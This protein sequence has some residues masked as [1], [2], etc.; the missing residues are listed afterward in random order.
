MGWVRRVNGFQNETQNRDLLGERIREMERERESQNESDNP[1]S[2]QN[3]DENSMP[4]NV[5]NFQVQN[6]SQN[7]VS[8]RHSLCPRLDLEK[9]KCRN[10]AVRRLS[11]A[12]NHWYCTE[13]AKKP[14]QQKT[15]KNDQKDNRRKRRIRR[16]STELPEVLPEDDSDEN[17]SIQGSDSEWN[18]PGRVQNYRGIPHILAKNENCGRKL[19]TV[20]THKS[21]HHKSLRLVKKTFW[22]KIENFSQTPCVEV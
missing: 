9:I 16:E 11:V 18:E 21:L 22:S 14:I 20:E 3:I 5:Q 13:R 7:Q 1:G 12:E 17:H 19:S 2:P 15:Q 10:S 4:L 6:R 8:N